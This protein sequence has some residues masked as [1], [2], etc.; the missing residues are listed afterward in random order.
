MT[1][2]PG[3]PIRRILTSCLLLMALSPGQPVR[4][5]SMDSSAFLSQEAFIN[6]VRNYH[7]VA[8][9]ANLL[10]DL[11]E[12][13]MIA[14][15]AGFD[16]LLYM[17]AEKKTFDGRNYYDIFHPELKIPTWYGIELKAGLEN[18]M[19]DL[20]N[21]EE[22]KGKTSYLGVSVPIGRNL[23]MDKR[24]AV[25]R[26]A[27]LYRE[28]SKSERLLAVNDLLYGAY[29]SYW[30]WVSAWAVYRILSD[31]V[32]L[33]E[34]RLGGIR[35]S[36]L[37]GDRAAIDTTEALAQLQTL[38]LAQGDAWLKFRSAG[39]E[40]SNHM[41]MANDSPYYLPPTVRPDSAW[42]KMNT[43][44]VK[45]PVLEDVLVAA[46]QGHPKLSV[47]D[48]KLQSLDIEKK[49]KF[50]GNLPLFNLNGNILN[51]GYN[52]FENGSWPY[53]QNNYKIGF[54]FVMPLRL[55][56]GRGEYRAAKIKIRDT[57]LGRAQ[58]AQEIAN[59]VRVYFYELATLQQQVRLAGDNSQNYQRLFL[60][61]ETRYRSGE[62]SLFLVNAREVRSL[63]AKQ[64]L[65]ELRAKFF[66]CYY[67]LEW[68]AGQ[69]R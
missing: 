3:S 33:N 19:G 16:P 7:P 69:L 34:A 15:R 52:V 28:Q 23:V 63:E 14:S 60:V 11:A 41:W 4:G 55:S 8:R 65:A 53:Y 32:H 40:L 46:R 56:Q 43:E 30:N 29:S 54:D 45:L 42:E 37:Q 17:S 59:K 68:A 36:Y 9:Q 44:T 64:K 58:D 50:Q 10:I 62:S 18:N 22:S 24:R 20:L 49:L 13:Q 2:R 5:Q 1:I 21:P 26:Q 67:A 31:Q 57:E 27:R 6:I 66:K 12:A 47:Y 48:F 51:K 39:L 25:L 35:T 38:Q 61:E